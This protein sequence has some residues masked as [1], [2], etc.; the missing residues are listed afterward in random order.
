MRFYD[1]DS[2]AARPNLAFMPSK[3]ITAGTLRRVPITE[4]CQEP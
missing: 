3:V 4:L 1:K 2:M